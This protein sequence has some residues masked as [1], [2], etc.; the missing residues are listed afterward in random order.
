MSQKTPASEFDLNLRTI[1]KKVLNLSKFIE[2]SIIDFDEKEH[3]F[4]RS[5]KSKLVI[6]EEGKIILE[7]FPILEGQNFSENQSYFFVPIKNNQYVMDLDKNKD[8]EFA[9]AVDHGGN[10]PSARA[11]VYS[12]K[13]SKI[14]VFKEAWYQM[15][16]GKEVIWNE[17]EA[18]KK[19]LFVA[20]D[21][22][23]YL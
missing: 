20:Q 16:N 2:V 7:K 8:Y 3:D 13:G 11:T 1:G 23:E 12:M 17:E 10:A 22:C 5:W 9:I 14:Q 19:C 6:K 4:Y 15:E 21:I 18:P